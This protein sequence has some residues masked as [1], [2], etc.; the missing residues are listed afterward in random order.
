MEKQQRKKYSLL[1]AAKAAGQNN[2]CLSFNIST[3]FSTAEERLEK[4]STA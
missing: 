4:S 2:L 3:H 1:E